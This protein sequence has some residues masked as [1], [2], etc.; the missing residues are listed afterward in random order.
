MMTFTHRN[1]RIDA[2]RAAIDTSDAAIAEMAG[3]IRHA[4]DQ[5]AAGIPPDMDPD[6]LAVTRDL[7]TKAQVRRAALDQDRT[8][9]GFDRFD[10][11]DANAEALVQD[12]FW[13]T[14][15]GMADFLAADPVLV[16]L[17]AGPALAAEAASV[18]EALP[19]GGR[20]PRPGFM[21][22]VSAAG[23]VGAALDQ[24]TGIVLSDWL[25]RPV[26]DRSS[27]FEEIGVLLPLRLETL[28]EDSDAGWRML[29]RIIP[30]EPSIRRDNPNVT[31]MEAQFLAEFWQASAAAPVA[32]AVD[33]LRDPGG[34]VAWEILSDRVTPQ[35]AAWLLTSFPPQPV[36]GVLAASVPGDRIG[37]PVAQRIHGLPPE[38]SVTIV[39]VDGH[40]FDLDV[41]TPKLPEEHLRVPH[42]EDAFDSWLMSWPKAKDVGMGGE[43]LLPD[44]VTPQR[45]AALYV[46]GL[47]D[48]PPSELFQAHAAAGQLGLVRL[49][50]ATNTVQGAP[51]ADLALDGETWRKVVV[52]R[53]GGPAGAGVSDLGQALC[54]DPFA[55]PH[56]P[57]TSHD[58]ED[59]RL[60]VATL[61][62]ALRG[63][64]FRDLWGGVDE[65]PFFWQWAIEWL[66]PEGPYPP[67]RIADQPYG[68][69]PVAS[70][71]SWEAADAT[72]WDRMEDRLIFGLRTLL[73]RWAE[74]AAGRGT[75]AGASTEEL[76]GH[77]ARPGV[78]A[79]YVY[80]SFVAADRLVGAYSD[81]SA[82]FLDRTR[83]AWEETAKA[84]QQ[85][86]LR[87]YL[88]TGHSAPLRLPLIGSDRLLPPDQRLRDVFNE[89]YE[90]NADLFASAFYS[91]HLGNIVPKSLLVRL[92][93]HS[94]VLAKAWLVQS[95]AQPPGTMPLQNPLFWDDPEILTDVERFQGSFQFSLQNADGLLRKLVD[96]HQKMIFHLAGELD[97]HLVRD[98][99]PIDAASQNSVMHLRL[100][101]EREAELDRALRATLDAM[102]HRIDHYAT[103][104]ANRRLRSHASGGRGRHRLGAYGWLDG[105][106]EG[107]PGPTAAG[108]LHAPSHAQS[109][110]S[111]ILRDKYLSAAREL[112]AGDRNI[113]QMNLSSRT[114]RMAIDMADEVRMGFHIFEI[115]GR[116]V[117][118][119]V[120]RP[121]R[122][123]TLRKAKPLRDAAPDGRD[124]CHGLDALDALLANTI[125]G[126]L[127][128]DPD[129]GRTQR[130][131][132]ETLKAA[133]EAYSDLLVAEGVHQ[134]VTGHADLAADA[135]DA[136]AGLGR[137]PSLDFARTPSSG[138]RLGT[139]VLAVFPHREAGAQ[140]TPIE[141]ADASLAGFIRGRV[142]EADQWV[143]RLLS[144]DG[145]PVRVSLA[146]LGLSPLDTILIT[147]DFLVEAVRSKA[148]LPL[149][150]VEAPGAHRTAQQLARTLGS[151]ALLADV[152]QQPN[153]PDAEQHASEASLRLELTTR[154]EAVR[155]ELNRLVEAVADGMTD[156]ECLGWL[157][158]VVPWGIVGSAKGR[159]GSPLAELLFGGR[160]PDPDELG[161]LVTGAR[162]SLTARLANAPDEP[163]KLSAASLALAIADL[164]AG[165]RLTLTARW[166]RA[167]LVLRSGLASDLRPAG[168]E[169]DWLATT[170][171]VRPQLARLEA[172]QLEARF[173]GNGVPFDAH[174]NSPDDLWRTDLVKRNA[175]R[176]LEP[177]PDRPGGS[178]LARLDL[179]RLVVSFGSD[180]AWQADNVAVA[181]IDQFSEAVP[182][183][184]RSTYAAFGFNAPAARPPQAILLA[185]PPRPDR[186]LGPDA[187]F[188]VLEQTR[189]LLRARAARPEDVGQY[190]ATPTMWFDGAS[191]LRL[192]LD[193]GT[194]YWR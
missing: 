186:A 118:G 35:R 115:V 66:D 150:K 65:M 49:G 83:Q 21:G 116:R 94:V 37:A 111:I 153:V 129:R 128:D 96:H 110:T 125:P 123:R 18:I 107:T 59:G 192:R 12:W 92:M 76:L 126:V 152:S 176:R 141:L 33:W 61:W 160:A 67:I 138:Y 1:R 104:I 13:R 73:P 36:D 108:R 168:L 175:E 137:P 60:M 106:F 189:E 130:E 10:T 39:D 93:I 38:L 72:D 87:T 68:L 48:A 20:G 3:R 40:R 171:S 159:G 113:W 52:N 29:L 193:N 173:L 161:M 190:P 177:D 50:A 164:A 142:G 77:L 120:G 162:D 8:A 163:A 26:A 46:Y 178:Q 132:L 74:T 188:D 86:P 53:L 32:Q 51:A 179:Q 174:C 28:F 81:V 102:G 184:E 89:L 114:V 140:A 2:V 6:T 64:H 25:R 69:L 70:F 24:A 80:R 105:P 187:L 172:L 181:L 41:L 75:V 31:A 97:E 95:V 100:P 170:A 44:Q 16:A 88:A 127:D 131:Q 151:P 144:E 99:D 117:E 101:A 157:R 155:A 15:A 54:G 109:L 34:I 112:A 56:L 169:S 85:E 191:P 133:L 17:E 14:T 119:I 194:Q 121:D 182:M 156:A 58:M 158:R 185:V 166:S 19:R 5:M 79:R 136:A 9:L 134:V 147:E 62:P 4:E 63:H 167:D 103:G 23:A 154:L 55:L 183:A 42:N 124:T 165:G 22:E 45:I 78:S 90:M 84:L 91:R 30:D 148:A 11:S 145:E 180:D 146:D 43:F 57:G 149:A 7:L 122:V 27:P 139:S 98:V 47:G 135:M 143:W 71:R 82:E